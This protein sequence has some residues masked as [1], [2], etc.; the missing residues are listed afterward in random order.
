MKKIIILLVI[1]LN[2]GCSNDSIIEENTGLIENPNK[3]RL[4]INGLIQMK[5]LWKSVRI[6]VV[7][8]I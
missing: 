5:I 3:I 6:L 2:F 1:V 4:K 7:I 8:E